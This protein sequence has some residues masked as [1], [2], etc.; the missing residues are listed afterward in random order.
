MKIRSE[1]KKKTATMLAAV[2][3]V[4]ALLAGCGETTN[5]HDAPDTSAVTKA[6]KERTASGNIWEEESKGKFGNVASDSDYSAK[7]ELDDSK[8]TPITG[9]ELKDGQYL[10]DSECNYSMFK[11]ADSLLDVKNGSMEATLL[12]DS[13]SFEYMYAGTA[14]EASKAKTDSYIAFEKNESGAQLYRIPVEALDKSLSYAAYSSEKEKWYDVALM[15]LSS[16]L[17]EEA[18]KVARYT[19]VSALGLEDGFYYVDV[20]LEGGTGKASVMSPSMISVREGMVAAMLMWS[21]DKYDYMIVDGQRY[22]ADTSAGQSEFVI[23]VR[24]FDHKIDVIADTTAMS[25]P[26]EIEYTLYFDSATIQSADG[27]VMPSM[28]ESLKKK[29]KMSLKYAKQ[30]SADEYEDGIY[31]VKAG[32]EEYLIVPKETAVPSNVP[33]EVTVIRTPVENAYMASTSSMDFFRELGILDKVGFAGAEADKWTDSQV[34]SMVKAGKIKY[35]GKYDAPEYESLI[36][37]KADLAVENTM[38]Y[39]S[40]DTKEKL[41]ELSIPVIVDMTSYETDP[42]GRVEWIKLYG[43]LTGKYDEAVKFF[44][45]SCTEIA[46][47][48]PSSKQKPK[49]AYFYVSPK[50]H[51]GVRKPGDYISKEIEM[52][53]GKYIPAD[54]KATDEDDEKESSSMEMSME[55]FFLKAKDADIIIYNSTLYGMP[56]SVA[57]LTKDTSLLSEFKAV[58]DG[59]V[60]ATKDN[61]FQD[62]SAAAEVITELADIVGGQDRSMT[63]FQKLK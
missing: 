6:V 13:N 47:V 12:M 62:T 61:M 35:V 28:Y 22:D 40:P 16:S 29:G 53:G 32:D 58:K 20:K 24:G 31:K 17:S 41:E 27:G 33:E 45:E 14:G 11:I 56:A 1:Y 38:I 19:T 63:Y 49:V 26:H 48:K 15:F 42:R 9:A 36:T 21:S 25:K 18:F 7:E 60:Y 46:A 3:T 59:R 30:F 39:H 55:D 4:M 54:V 34:S 57:D 52:A 8:L 50:G 2:M 51:V 43:L 23:P 44:D 5:V 37:G 10:I